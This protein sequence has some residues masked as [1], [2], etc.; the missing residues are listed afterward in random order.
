LQAL[1]IFANPIPIGL[2]KSK[3]LMPILLSEECQALV[4]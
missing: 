4:K 1:L 3:L 2:L